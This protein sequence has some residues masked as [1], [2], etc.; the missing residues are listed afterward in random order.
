MKRTLP[1]TNKERA[2]CTRDPR[3]GGAYVVD[4]RDNAWR[5][6][7][8]APHAHR[9]TV[10]QVVDRPE[11]GGVGTAK[12]V[13]RP[14]QQP[15]QPQCGNYWAPLTPKQHIPPHP[16]QPQHTNDGAP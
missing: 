4:G 6:G 3:S 2:L 13:K 14:P 15:A 9:N 5:S 11:D 8:P 10:R 16:A 12:T 1:A 7:A